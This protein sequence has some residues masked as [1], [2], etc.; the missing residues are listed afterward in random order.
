M[1]PR[2]KFFFLFV[3][4][5]L[6]SAIVQAGEDMQSRVDSSRKVVKQFASELKGHLKKAVHGGGPAKAIYVCAEI[7]PEIAMKLSEKNNRHVARTS[8]KYRN[9][10]NA[11]DLWEKE[12]LKEFEKRK[13]AGEPPKNLEHYEIVEKNGVRAF[14]YMKA[15]PTKTACLICHGSDISEDVSEALDRLYPEDRAR[16]FKKGDIRGA[17]TIEQPIV[18]SK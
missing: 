8:L 12:V 17:F 6:I 10:D 9:T 1:K 2:S 5:T 18:K 13:A 14:R 11:P 7:A 16:G 15:I 3:I 4:A